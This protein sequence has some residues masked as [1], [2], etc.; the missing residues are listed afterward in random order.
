MVMHKHPTHKNSS[1]FTLIE[2]L[3][4]IAIIGILSAVAIPQYNKYKIRGY[5]AHSKQALRDMHTLCNAYWLDTDPDQGCD[6][7]I[8]KDTYY[9]FNQN[10]EI[11]ATL[12]PSPLDNF[13]GA[14][15]HNSSPNTYSIDSA[16]MISD[17]GDCGLSAE[18]AAQAE[19]ARIADVE[20]ECSR[21]KIGSVERTAATLSF[22]KYGDRVN[23]HM[24]KYISEESCYRTWMNTPTIQRGKRDEQGKAVYGNS[25]R[26]HQSIIN[27][28]RRFC[29]GNDGSRKYRC[30]TRGHARTCQALNE[31][32]IPSFDQ[33]VANGGYEEPSDTET[34][35]P[36]KR[37]I[38]NSFNHPAQASEGRDEYGLEVGVPYYTTRSFYCGDNCS[39]DCLE[40]QGPDCTARVVGDFRYE[41]TII[42]NPVKVFGLSGQPDRLYTKS[43]CELYTGEC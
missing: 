12:P 16:A 36:N 1:G 28:Y 26:R 8:I 3:I 40:D 9:G 37:A 30:R 21:L 38:I 27:Q 13:C 17:N 35:N 15:K 29:E 5:D 20:K 39:A 18:L 2:I 22:T 19:A 6:I 34:S 11:I 10:P 42:K 24:A 31:E 14:A 4:G 25:P 7:P 33:C 43:G 41:E 32:N 23:S